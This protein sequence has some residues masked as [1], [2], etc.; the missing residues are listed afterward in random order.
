MNTE[1]LLDWFDSLG[2]GYV[3]MAEEEKLSFAVYIDRRMKEL[4]ISRS[5]LAEKIGS[6]P[7][8]ISKVLRGDKNLTIESMAKLAWHVDAKL[9]IY[10]SRKDCDWK[11]I[12][13]IASPSNKPIVGAEDWASVANEA[14]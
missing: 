12:D 11:I 3:G 14:A 2:H 5:E 7:A 13:V 6:S 8:Y 1:D 4:G 10:I 9:H